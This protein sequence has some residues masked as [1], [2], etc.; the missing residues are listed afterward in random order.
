MGKAWARPCTIMKRFNQY[1]P[2][3]ILFLAFLLSFK[4]STGGNEFEINKNLDIFFSS[5]KELDA[6]YV[7]EIDPEKLIQTGIDAMLRELDPYTTFIPESDLGNYDFQTTGKYGGIGAVIRKIDNFVTVIDPYVDFPAYNAGLRAGDKILR[8]DS[9]DVEGRS[10]NYLSKKMRGAPGTPVTLSVLSPGKK[11]SKIVTITRGKIQVP[12]IDF[13]GIVEGDVGYVRLGQFTRQASNELRNEIN[14]LKSAGAKKLVF[15]LRGN[16]GGLLSEAVAITNLFIPR[17]KEVVSTRGR[18]SE[19]QKTYKTKRGAD[20]PKIPLVV[21]I[22]GS[23]ASASEIVSGAIQDYDRGVVIGQQSFGKG[24]VQTTRGLPYKNKVKIT[25][26]KY[27]IP[28]GRCIQAI[29]Y[30]EKGSGGSTKIPD[31]LRSSFKTANGRTVLDGAGIDPDIEVE[32]RSLARVAIALQNANLI[33]HFANDY[34]FR[35]PKASA[36]TKPRSFQLSDKDFEAFKLFVRDAD[37]EYQTRGELSLERLLDD[38][39]E[40][41]FKPSIESEVDRLEQL[42]LIEKGKD[43]DRFKEDVV[44]LLEQEIIGRYFFRNGR[45]EANLDK[46]PVILEAVKLVKD[47][48]KISKTLQP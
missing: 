44:F 26:A 37:Y 17:G 42:L 9:E 27:Y 39:K 24:L 43:L 21:L 46:D 34:V 48:S 20:F 30:S 33:F 1:H 45:Q 16:P 35:N 10:S 3:A 11:E 5:L 12:S 15:D 13:S 14:Q 32:D 41:G 28:S 4:G 25:T 38:A 40:E 7:D 31:S 2:L 36:A 47:A 8:I 18:L 22:N 29:D 23:S 19:W 6:H